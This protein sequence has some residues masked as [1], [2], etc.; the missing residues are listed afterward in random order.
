MK[1]SLCTLALTALSCCPALADIVA[2]RPNRTQAPTFP[3]AVPQ[4]SSAI[5][6][7]VVLTVAVVLIVASIVLFKAIRAHRK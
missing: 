6:L 3:E 4:N 5:S 7:P 1:K 2:P